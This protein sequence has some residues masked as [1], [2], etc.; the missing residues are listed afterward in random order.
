MLFSSYH[1]EYWAIIL[2]AAALLCFGSGWRS[3][4]GTWLQR[5]HCPGSGWVCSLLVSLSLLIWDLHIFAFANRPWEPVRIVVCLRQTR[6]D[7]KIA[8]NSKYRVQM[9]GIGGWMEVQRRTCSN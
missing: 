3:L 4:D 2:P 9:D 6:S 7:L 1:S 8:Y 5:P